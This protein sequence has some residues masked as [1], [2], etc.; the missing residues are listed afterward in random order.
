MD[1]EETAGSIEMAYGVWGVVGPS[2]HVLDGGLD[3]PVVRGNFWGIPPQRIA[4]QTEAVI[5]QMASPRDTVWSGHIWTRPGMPAVDI[6]NKTML[7]F[8]ELLRSL[9]LINGGEGFDVLLQ[10]RLVSKIVSVVCD[11]T[12][13][14]L[15]ELRQKR[16]EQ[17]YYQESCYD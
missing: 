3:P 1:A 7:P 12:T 14:Q 13:L 4:L 6:F 15:T 5:R 10:F 11:A 17:N 8:I 9:A 2:N 16:T